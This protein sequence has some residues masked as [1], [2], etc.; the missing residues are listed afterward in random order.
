VEFTVVCLSNDAHCNPTRICNAIADTCLN[1]CFSEEDASA[2]PKNERA[3]IDLPVLG[4]ESKVGFFHG[5]TGGNIWDVTVED[6]KLMVFA[7]EMGET[8]QIRPTGQ[9][10]FVTTEFYLDVVATFD[11]I[12]AH[13][14]NG[15]T[16]CVDGKKAERLERIDRVEVS[17]DEFSAYCGSFHSIEL[18]ATYKLSIENEK[19]AFEFGGLQKVF[20]QAVNR[21]VFNCPSVG[22]FKFTFDETDGSICGFNLSAGRIREIEFSKISTAE[23]HP[24]RT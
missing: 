22:I 17:I 23:S 7:H 1:D 10:V 19:I 2:T 12:D 24:S 21:S 18:G 15:L 5:E 14:C 8:F 9:H 20:L 6:G 11:E 3:F 13:V 16:V 4:L